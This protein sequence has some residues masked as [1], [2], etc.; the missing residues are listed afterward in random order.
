MKFIKRVIFWYTPYIKNA[1]TVIKSSEAI[2]K[3]YGIFLKFKDISKI[4]KSRKNSNTV[5]AI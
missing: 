4:S 5:Q 1:V 3:G 2:F